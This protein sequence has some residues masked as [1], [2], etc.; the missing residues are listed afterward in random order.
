LRVPR[1]IASKNRLLFLPKAILQTMVQ[2]L[3]IKLSIEPDLQLAAID[4]DW[5][6]YSFQGQEAARIAS[7]FDRYIDTV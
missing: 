4:T 7:F 2:H 3:T 5:E 1:S 6:I